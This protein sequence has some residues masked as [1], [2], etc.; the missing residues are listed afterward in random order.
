MGPA[1]KGAIAGIAASVVL[2]VG[3]S[4]LSLGGMVMGEPTVIVF[5]WPALPSC[6]S[7]HTITFWQKLSRTPNWQTLSRR[8]SRQC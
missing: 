6:R 2:G 7:C 1:V 3:D 5:R 4:K 8:L